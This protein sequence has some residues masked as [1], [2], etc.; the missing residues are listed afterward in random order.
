[1]V[2]WRIKAFRGDRLEMVG[3]WPSMGSCN[4]PRDV[5]PPALNLDFHI[6]CYRRG[7]SRQYP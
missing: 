3:G 5:R 4:T 7:P 2:A 1:M 6:R